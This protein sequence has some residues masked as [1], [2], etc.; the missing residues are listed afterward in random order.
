MKDKFEHPPFIKFDR[1]ASFGL[2]GFSRALSDED[3]AFIK[4]KV[5]KVSGKEVSWVPA[6]GTSSPFIHQVYSLTKYMSLF[7]QRRK[8]KPSSSS[9][10][11]TQ[12]AE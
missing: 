2:V 5:T 9:G 1:G 4:E 6:E 12:H 8:R 3:L 10:L 11:R 7:L